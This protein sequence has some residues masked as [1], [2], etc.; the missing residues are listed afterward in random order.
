MRRSF[1]RL[2]L[3]AASVVACAVSDASPLSAQQILAASDAVR[4]PDHPFGVT[5]RLTE[6]R[7]GKQSDMSVLTVYSKAEPDSGQFRSLI[8]F[9]APARDANK[10]MLKTGNDVW[11][12]DPASKASIRVSPQQRLLGQAANGDVV[13]VN[14]AKDYQAQLEGEEDIA[15]GEK[16]QR[17][18][19]RLT[20]KAVSPDVTYHSVEIW[21]DVAG[22]RPVKARFLS[23][24]GRL[25]KTAYYRRYE[26][27]LGN[28]RPTETVIIDG[29]DS[30]W[31][32]I[33][34]GSDYV[35]RDVQDF[36][37]QRDYLPRFN[38]D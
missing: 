2:G 38:P 27:Q 20:L 36:W 7:G 21:I 28:I 26:S 30:G 37:F 32:T 29:V 10:L 17:H 15:D 8:R 31:V 4:N 19:Y 24:S 12:Y 22:N 1:L 33:M 14:L 16:A 18:C 9:I 6:Y 13:T 3:L 35:K 23:E 25:L 11:F 34:R 5:V